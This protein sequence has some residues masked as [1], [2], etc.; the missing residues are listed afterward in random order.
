MWRARGKGTRELEKTQSQ[1]LNFWVKSGK[2]EERLTFL[3]C[4][5]ELECDFE[6]LGYSE[7]DGLCLERQQRA[8]R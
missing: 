8:A 6:G 2:R 7:G 3:S 1:P 4:L 5:P